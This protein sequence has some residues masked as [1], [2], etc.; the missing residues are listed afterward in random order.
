M[1]SMAKL[2]GIHGVSYTLGRLCAG[3]CLEHGTVP[4]CIDCQG[5]HTDTGYGE[6]NTGS[7]G[8]REG[9]PAAEPAVLIRHCSRRNYSEANAQK[10]T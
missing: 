2:L 8:G 6:Q 7:P 9:S 10:P 1:L 3:H 4:L 5:Q